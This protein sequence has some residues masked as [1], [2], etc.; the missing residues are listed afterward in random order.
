MPGTGRRRKR[1]CNEHIAADQ[2]YPT[3]HQWFG[4]FLIG[5]GRLAEGL[6]E[7]SRAHQL[8]P[9]SRQIAVEWGWTSY[10]MHQYDTAEVHI[11]QVLSLDPN[12]AQAHYRLGLVEIQQ[13]HYPE[14][15]ASLKRA[16][17]LGAFLPQVDAA[18]AFAYAQ[19]GSRGEALKIVNDLEQRAAR[20]LVPPV[21]LAIAYAGLGDVTRG[22][23]W[24]NRAIDQHD[25][26]V[27]ENFFELLL[28]PLRKDPRFETVLTRMGLA[29]SRH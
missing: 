13:R 10:L 2:N 11:R 27:P 16:I 5:R 7:M 12:Y 21:E 20:E 22:L 18:L 8:D 14:A 3:G 15:I 24:L 23:E 28:D 1:T 29:A 6:A 9:L 17:D 25:F 19:S 4:D 26:Y